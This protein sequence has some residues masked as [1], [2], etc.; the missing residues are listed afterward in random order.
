MRGEGQ[1]KR[2]N[3]NGLVARYAALSSHVIFIILYKYIFNEND[4][5][6]V[7]SVLMS[8]LITIPFKTRFECNANSVIIPIPI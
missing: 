1:L 5:Y 7:S 6:Q 2:T 8:R 3:E 4:E